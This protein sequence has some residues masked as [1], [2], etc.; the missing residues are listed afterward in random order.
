MENTNRQERGTH[1]KTLPLFSLSLLFCFPSLHF[2]IL[3][4]KRMGI[5]EG[6]LRSCSD[7]RKQELPLFPAGPY[8]VERVIS[9]I[10]FVTIFINP[11][12]LGFHPS[13]CL[14]LHF[15]KYTAQSVPQITICSQNFVLPTFLPLSKE[16]C[17]FAGGISLSWQP[18]G[19]GDLII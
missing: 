6:H 9:K 17:T 15:F 1:I 13:F 3:K 16:K 2:N 7:F 5:D 8:R 4:E 14:L 10:V 19:A 12:L 18:E 11:L